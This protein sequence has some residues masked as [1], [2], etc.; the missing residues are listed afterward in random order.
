MLRLVSFSDR[1][2][3]RF[4][5]RSAAARGARGADSRF[6]PPQGP[7]SGPRREINAECSLSRERAHN[8]EN[9]CILWRMSTK[10]L[11]N[12]AKRHQ[13]VAERSKTTPNRCRTPQ[14]DPKSLQNAAKRPQIVAERRKT[15]PNRCRTQQDDP[16]LMQNAAKGPQISAENCK[17]TSN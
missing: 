16:K 5:C 1:P 7:R 15:T 11:Q 17:T 3:Q 2:K 9:V 4:R 10:T 14:N 13:I 8:L 6:R 12:G